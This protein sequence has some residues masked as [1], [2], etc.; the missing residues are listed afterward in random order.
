[1]DGVAP[2][3]RTRACRCVALLGCRPF[4]PASRNACR[5]F[6]ALLSKPKKNRSP[7]QDG[8][9]KTR[10]R[11]SSEWFAARQTVLFLAYGVADGAGFALNSSANT[12]IDVR[13]SRVPTDGFPAHPNF[14]GGSEI[15]AGMRDQA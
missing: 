8:R 12:G 4:V 15:Q 13:D 5:P 6:R 14:L 11:H 7:N 1:M 2:L 9:R 10:S 3:G